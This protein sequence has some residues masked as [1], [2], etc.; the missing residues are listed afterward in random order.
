MDHRWIL[1]LPLFTDAT[2]HAPSS[3]TDTTDDDDD[4]RRTK[5][6]DRYVDPLDLVDTPKT[7]H[8]RVIDHRRAAFGDGESDDDDSDEDEV[9]AQRRRRITSSPF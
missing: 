2:R 7:S 5:T 3:F 8:V 1:C 9:D 4:D 6:C